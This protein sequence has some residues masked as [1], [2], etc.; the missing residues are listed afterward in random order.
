VILTEQEER[1][2][3]SAEAR[4][5]RAASLQERIDRIIAGRASRRDRPS[6]YKRRAAGERDQ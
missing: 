4:A 5:A 6:D 3:F 1:E 2:R